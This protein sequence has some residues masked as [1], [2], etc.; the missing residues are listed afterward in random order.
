MAVSVLT[1]SEF[2]GGSDDDLL[3]VRRAT[4]LP[5]LRKDFT[6]DAYQIHEARALG[7]DAVLLIARILA[8]GRL[9][10][11]VDL[12]R[13]LRLTAL[14]EIHDEDELKAALEARAAVVGVNCRDLRSFRT[15]LAVAER[16]RPLIPQGTL[17]VAESGIHCPADVETVRRAGFDACLVGEALMAAPDP[18]ESLRDLLRDP[19]EDS[20]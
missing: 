11:W 10:E 19:V 5:L 2:F 20:P 13:E 15:D 7:A 6:V 3:A 8:D 12:C 1:D 18:G 17:A 16:L 9:S 4:R 14:V